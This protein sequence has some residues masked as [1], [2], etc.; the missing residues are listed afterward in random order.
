M[1][2]GDS[3]DTNYCQC[4]ITTEFIRVKYRS[5][6]VVY[7]TTVANYVIVTRSSE[8]LKTKWWEHF[9]ANASRFSKSAL[10][11]GGFPGFTRF[12]LVNEYA[13]MVE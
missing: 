3:P 5:S 11:F 8:L 7:A 1:N 10:I 6:T 12:F 9:P 13:A 2:L 4:T